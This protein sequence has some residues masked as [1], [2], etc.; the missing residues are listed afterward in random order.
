MGGRDLKAWV[1]KGKFERKGK[2][3]ARNTERIA[4]AEMHTGHIWAHVHC[5]TIVLKGIL[6][7]KMVLCALEKGFQPKVSLSHLFSS[8]CGDQ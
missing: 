5:G 8:G 1:L 2:E 7:K 3:E 4:E 6:R